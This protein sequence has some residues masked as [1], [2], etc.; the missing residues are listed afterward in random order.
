MALKVRPSF[1]IRLFWDFI[2]TYGHSWSGKYF[3]QEDGN[4]L[5]QVRYH[6]VVNKSGV[7]IFT[8]IHGGQLQSC[9]LADDH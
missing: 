5:I 9:L 3:R 8:A 7:Y 4:I 2:S 6:Q 1:N